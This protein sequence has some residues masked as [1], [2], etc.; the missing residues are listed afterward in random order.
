MKV[1]VTR[2]KT[3]S[4]ALAQAAGTKLVF[5]YHQTPRIAEVIGPRTGK[6]GEPQVLVWQTGGGSNAG[7]LPGYRRMAVAKMMR[8]RTRT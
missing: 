2:S 3:D 1:R 5:R 4:I 8:V 6:N 7:T